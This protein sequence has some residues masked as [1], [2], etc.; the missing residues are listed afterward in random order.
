M[1]VQKATGT[2]PL[3]NN[4]R[5]VKTK[6]KVSA[7][8]NKKKF[9]NSTTL[10]KKP[11]RNNRFGNR[12]TNKKHQSKKPFEKLPC[13]PSKANNVIRHGNFSN[14]TNNKTKMKV[15]ANPCRNNNVTRSNK[16]S[17]TS[18]TNRGTSKTKSPTKIAKEIQDANKGDGVG[19]MFR[20]YLRRLREKIYGIES[21]R[22]TRHVYSDTSRTHVRELKE[23]CNE[24]HVFSV[25]SEL[26]KCDLRNV[27]SSEEC[28]TICS[29][30]E[31]WKNSGHSSR[32][33]TNTKDI[34][35][36]C[37][38]NNIILTN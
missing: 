4:V 9:N 28:K 7:T 18:K 20:G 3:G 2:K 12:L 27:T 19:D 35:C 13:K 37:K 14:N 32:I 23:N 15:N 1:Q 16:H 33:F 21:A 8:G 30:V 17:H 11:F 36:L 26:E 10:I 25:T 5:K 24:K 38:Y 22:S 31:K 6:T 29:R 34:D